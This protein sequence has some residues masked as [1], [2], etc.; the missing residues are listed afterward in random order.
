MGH[1]YHGRQRTNL[2]QALRNLIFGAALV[3]R[4][5]QRSI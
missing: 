1:P 4:C 5:P 3:G 2:I